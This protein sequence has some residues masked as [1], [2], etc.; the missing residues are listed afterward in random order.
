MKIVRLI[1]SWEDSKLEDRDK[2]T[3]EEWQ[4][5]VEHEIALAKSRGRDNIWFK[6][7]EKVEKEL[8]KDK[9]HIKRMGGFKKFYV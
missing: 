7:L 2:I 8:L 5:Y 6:P 9:N 4:R 1:C 3:M